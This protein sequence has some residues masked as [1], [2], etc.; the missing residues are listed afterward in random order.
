M[1]TTGY[2]IPENSNF[3]N[4]HEVCMVDIN[5]GYLTRIP[6]PMSHEQHTDKHNMFNSVLIL[7]YTLA[8][9]LYTLINDHLNSNMNTS[10]LLTPI[11]S[12]YV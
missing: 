3:H 10:S 2:H 7:Q 8:V 12:K 9:V 4:K 6:G 5:T 1:Y 11:F